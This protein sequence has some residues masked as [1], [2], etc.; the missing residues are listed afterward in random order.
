MLEICATWDLLPGV[1]QDT[2]AAWAKQAVATIL[3]QPGLVEFRGNRNLL[4]SPEVRITL[5]WRSGADWIAFAEGAW[6]SVERELRALATHIRL[7]VWGPSPIVPE[8]LRPG[9]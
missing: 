3:K 9:R 5:L 7:E 6:K 8:P 1:S 2:Y 4:G